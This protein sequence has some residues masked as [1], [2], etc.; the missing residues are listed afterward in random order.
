MDINI[1]KQPG[2]RK[3]AYNLSI[4]Y[5]TAWVIESSDGLTRIENNINRRFELSSDQYFY[6][7]WQR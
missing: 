5:P 6:L 3:D 2:S 7:S 1:Y 4:S